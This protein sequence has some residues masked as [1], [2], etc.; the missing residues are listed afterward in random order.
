MTNLSFHCKWAVAVWLIALTVLPFC[1]EA[2][3]IKSYIRKGSKLFKKEKYASAL[4]YFKD[5]MSLEAGN[6]EANYYAARCYYEL[7]S[8]NEALLH[9]ERANRSFSGGKG[10]FYYWL[11]QIRFQNGKIQTA[12]EA[13]AQQ[14]ASF[15]SEKSEATKLLYN[16]VTNS[17]LQAKV[18][19]VG[20][21]ENLG[22]AINTEF[23]EYS[24]VLTD[25]QRTIMFTAKRAENKGSSK[26]DEITE[27]I[28]VS[29]LDGNNQ[30]QPPKRFP[31]LTTAGNDATVQL[32]NS[33]KSMLLYQKGDLYLSEFQEGSWSTPQS[34][35]TNI[36]NK[37]S[38]ESHGFVTDGGNT[39]VFAS[40]NNGIQGSLD[41]FISRKRNGE[42]GT[43]RAIRELNTPFDEDSPF[44]AENGTL[45]FS[46][47]G[48]NSIGGYDIFR[49]QYNELT[50]R[51]SQPENLGMPINSIFDDIFFN[52]KGQVAYFTSNRAGGKG[53]AD[54]YRAF[55]FRKVRLSGRLL[56][57]NGQPVNQAYKMIF[58][59]E[60]TVFEIRS[61]VD[62]RYSLIIPHDYDY[63]LRI[64]EGQE[65]VL[66]T[67]FRPKISL[68]QPEAVI[69]D[70]ELPVLLKELPAVADT[71]QTV[72]ET[73][74]ATPAETPAKDLEEAQVEVPAQQ[75]VVAAKSR[76]P[77][78]FKGTIISGMVV[79]R[80]SGKPLA[81]SIK[82]IDGR[83]GE[84]VKSSVSDQ[85]GKYSLTV[86]QMLNYVLMA[87]RDG[88]ATEGQTIEPAEN[89]KVKPVDLGL[90]PNTWN[91][92]FVLE[93]LYFAYGSAELEP[94]SQ[95]E[96]D[97]TF[98]YLQENPGI[99]IEIAG[100]TDSVGPA[101]VNLRLSQQRANSVKEY[102]INRG[103]ASN[104]IKATGYGESRP[105]VSNDDERGGREI[106]RRIE[107]TLL[108]PVD[109]Q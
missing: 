93:R 27:D 106:N 40:D 64:L 46:S 1:A 16:N 85:D 52:L 9:I 57:A 43:P 60:D 24:A 48:Y 28:L 19:P 58:T 73:V 50:D 81:A 107:I 30:W 109:V 63:E 13:I 68:S 45:Y 49:S 83:T 77:S 44:V 2:Q 41:L 105:L 34:L 53:K 71:V 61:G 98:S 39:L 72:R 54:I 22:D 20:Y 33:G 38:R 102:L 66:L 65:E 36:N 56:A 76:K 88:Y 35:G 26:K 70:F 86:G 78:G 11:G 23:P 100:H 6:F 92:A 31:K 108:N 90:M 101:D 62:G 67:K 87:E 82:L 94:K 4:D 89:V 80:V 91:S 32:F 104:R 47:K 12:M 74:T 99:R 79:D 18:D 14:Q 69:R 7:S 96:L 17:M 5:A 8:P 25:D 95:V 55:L 97:S 21:I 37:Y 75:P 59:N 29:T 3:N 51:Y 103:I 84:L 15:P 10:D 42:W